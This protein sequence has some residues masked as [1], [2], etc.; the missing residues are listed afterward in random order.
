MDAVLL[1]RVVAGRPVI[2]AAVVPDHDVALFPFVMVLGVGLDHRFGQ[3]GDQFVALAA[4]DADKI[5]DLAGVE[6]ERLAAGLGM[7]ADDRVVDRRPLLVLGVRAAATRR[8][9]RRR[10]RRR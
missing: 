3:F 1:G 7:D 8:A 6:I 9:A 4:L 5:D 10:R 2:G